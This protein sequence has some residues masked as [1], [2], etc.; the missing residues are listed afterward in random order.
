MLPGKVL[1]K[2]DAADRIHAARCVDAELNNI[3]QGLGIA[4]VCGLTAYVL[5]KR[6][7]H[8]KTAHGHSSALITSE[9]NDRR[10]PW[11]GTDPVAGLPQCLQ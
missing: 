10:L 1:P 6:R 4:C 5:H 8:L 11:N 2:N 3:G 9:Q 7:F